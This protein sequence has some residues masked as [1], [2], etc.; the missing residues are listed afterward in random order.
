MG[1]FW[2][3]HPTQDQSAPPRGFGIDSKI[4]A[5]ALRAPAASREEYRPQA[6]LKLKPRNSFDF[7]VRHEPQFNKH[8]W[9]FP[10]YFLIGRWC[11]IENM[12]DL[13]LEHYL[14]ENLVADNDL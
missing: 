13:G 3:P 9:T 1:T 14:K 6:I 5:A 8:L 12:V 10:L 7:R 2:Q 4:D 11:E